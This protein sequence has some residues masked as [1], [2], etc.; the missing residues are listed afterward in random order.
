RQRY[1]HQV[2]LSSHGSSRHKYSAT[3]FLDNKLKRR[4]SGRIAIKNL[5]SISNARETMA[6]QIAPSRGSDHTSLVPR[7]LPPL[8]GK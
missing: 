3:P 1:F 8:P 6:M 7:A 5:Q 4:L 2:P